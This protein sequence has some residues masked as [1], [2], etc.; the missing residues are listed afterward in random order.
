M[1]TEHDSTTI[2]PQGKYVGP[3]DPVTRAYPMYR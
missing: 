3:R 1:A 2:P